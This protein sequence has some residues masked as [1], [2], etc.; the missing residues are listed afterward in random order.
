MREDRR[1]SAGGT[2][3][4]GENKNVAPA[5]GKELKT[6]LFVLGALADGTGM[7]VQI[8]GARDLQEDNGVRTALD[9]RPRRNDRSRETWINGGKE[10]NVGPGGRSV[11]DGPRG[12]C[13]G[14]G[15][16]GTLVGISVAFS[17]LK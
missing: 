13:R 10:D 5:M 15:A 16:S 9:R 17:I 6:S 7:N 8:T 2:K 1:D 12:Y 4:E 14:T 11:W 3:N